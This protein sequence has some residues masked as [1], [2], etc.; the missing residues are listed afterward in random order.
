MAY[1]GLFE[2]AMLAARMD[3][4][5][6]LIRELCQM[7][8]CGGRIQLMDSLT[9]CEVYDVAYFPNELIERLG[10]AHIEVIAES[11]SLSGFVV[12]VTLKTDRFARCVATCVAFVSVGFVVLHCLRRD[13]I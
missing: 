2:R 8:V 7:D 1:M 9:S 6:K 4:T 3:A 10:R 13:V 11:T 5:V 12:R